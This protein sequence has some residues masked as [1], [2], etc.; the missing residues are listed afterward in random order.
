[1]LYFAIHFWAFSCDIYLVSSGSASLGISS[2]CQ[3][4]FHR[5]NATITVTAISAVSDI[6]FHFGRHNILNDLFFQI[7]QLNLQPQIEILLSLALND[8]DKTVRIFDN[9]VINTQFSVN[10]NRNIYF[11]AYTLLLAVFLLCANTS[12]AHK[13]V[14]S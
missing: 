4:S 14:L 5:I 6:V 11:L 1:M 13:S 9:H 2:V 3:Y 12:N 7:L 10:I 8:D